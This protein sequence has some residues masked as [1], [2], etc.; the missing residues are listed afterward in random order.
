MPLFAIQIFMFQE[1]V[2][3]DFEFVTSSPAAMVSLIEKAPAQTLVSY[4]GLDIICSL[5]WN[6]WN[7]PNSKCH[8]NRLY[9]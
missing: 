2:D 3:C 5:I 8:I 7:L 9:N 1:N 4:V 6:N